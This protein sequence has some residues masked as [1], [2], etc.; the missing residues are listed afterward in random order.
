[1]RIIDGNQ[2]SHRIYDNCR[3]IIA[4]Q[5][6]LPELHIF[7]ASADPASLNFAEL[8]Q[9]RGSEIGVKVE[10]HKF[11]SEAAYTDLIVEISHLAANKPSAGIM[12]QL[13]L[14][15][16]LEQHRTE[17]LNAIPARQDVDGL[18]AHNQ[19]RILQ[20]GLH[21]TD[22]FMPA[23]VNAIWLCLLEV[24]STDSLLGKNVVIINHSMLIGKPLANLLL[25]AGATVTVCHQHTK[26]LSSYTQNA[27]ILI[28]AT[29]QVGLINADMVK[30]DSILIDVTSIKTDS[31][32]QGDITVSPE[33]DEK[34]MARTPVP[35]GV[36]PVTIACLLQ[37]VVRLAQSTK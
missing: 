20:S 24:T 22:G 9:K 19:G 12:L 29:G 34:I 11:A 25:S 6:L 7:V 13:P 18:N 33:L 16:T 23:T 21:A 32:F 17:I 36:G 26:D 27:D 28:S 1:M 10:I 4:E 5:Q 37:N 31:G 8:K 30:P 15:S 14:Y 2:I 35:G 3:E